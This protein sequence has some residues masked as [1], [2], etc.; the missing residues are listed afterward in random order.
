MIRQ[1]EAEKAWEK[2]QDDDNDNDDEGREMERNG[3]SKGGNP[4]EK[5]TNSSR[6][7]PI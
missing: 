4:Q 1:S 7:G 5:F 6:S 2:D 3:R